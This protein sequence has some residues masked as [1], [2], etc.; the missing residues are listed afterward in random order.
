MEILALDHVQ[1]A[2]PAGREDEARKFYAEHLGM[3][4]CP[5]PANL[6]ARGGVWF[7]AAA[8]KVRVHLAVEKDFRAARKAHPAFLVDDVIG[9]CK[10]I[11]DGDYE[12]VE[13]EPL[14]GYNRLYVYDPFGNRIELMQPL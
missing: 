4:E 14:E 7:E 12:V 3:K 6:Q 10:R 9:V 8:G 1:L 5:K 11:K 2:M 13:D